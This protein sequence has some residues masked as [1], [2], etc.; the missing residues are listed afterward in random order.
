MLTAHSLSASSVRTK[1]LAS[2]L[3]RT[4]RYSR[5]IRWKLPQRSRHGPRV[6]AFK[7]TQRQVELAGNCAVPLQQCRQLYAVVDAVITEAK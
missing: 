7:C 3:C 1:H 5:H 2:R 6:P 4:V